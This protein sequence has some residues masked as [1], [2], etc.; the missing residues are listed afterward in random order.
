[1]F[2]ASFF[3]K[4]RSLHVVSVPNLSP[5]KVFSIFL[6]SFFYDKVIAIRCIYE[7]IYIGNRSKLDL[8]QSKLALIIFLIKNMFIIM[9]VFLSGYLFIVLILFFNFIP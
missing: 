8:C 2:S 9:S 7:C 4:T 5:I 1:M 6:F 3:S